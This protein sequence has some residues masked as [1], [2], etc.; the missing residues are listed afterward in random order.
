VL[1]HT[2]LRPL[3]TSKDAAD[4]SPCDDKSENRET[5]PKDLDSADVNIERSL[6]ESAEPLSV[7]NSP[8]IFFFAPS[9]GNIQGRGSTSQLGRLG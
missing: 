8:A 4:S 5:D 6:Q 9:V 7:L 3:A 1:G 2:Y